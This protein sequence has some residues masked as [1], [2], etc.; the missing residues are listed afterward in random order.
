[1]YFHADANFGV[2]LHTNNYSEAPDYT[3]IS[4]L[5]LW[6]FFK[7]HISSLLKTNL[8]NF[9]FI[10]I[11]SY[12]N[13]PEFCSPSELNWNKPSQSLKVTFKAPCEKTDERKTLHRLL[14][15]SSWGHTCSTA[16]RTT[17]TWVYHSLIHLSDVLR[18]F[19]SVLRGGN[20]ELKCCSISS[21][22]NS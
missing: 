16:I 1:M 19:S 20:P 17:F 18:P 15:A 8:A 12:G 4:L 22:N 9:Q 11:N 21:F 10:P 6:R 7:P 2:F 13:F 14:A 3:M 5:M